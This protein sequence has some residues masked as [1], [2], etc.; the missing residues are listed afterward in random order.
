LQKKC[1][2]FIEK[3]LLVYLDHVKSSK[4]TCLRNKPALS[5]ERQELAVQRVEEALSKIKEDCSLFK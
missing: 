2:D 3:T 4:G 1:N 5:E